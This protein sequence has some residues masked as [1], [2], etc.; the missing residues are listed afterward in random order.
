MKNVFEIIKGIS[1]YKKEVVLNILSNAV[2]VF[3]SLFSFV[4]VI[5]FVSVLFGI[6]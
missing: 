3:F 5:P 1:K 2:Y 4:V 6:T